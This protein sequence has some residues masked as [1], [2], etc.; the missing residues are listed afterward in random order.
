MKKLFYSE[1]LRK[2]FENE[3]DCVKAEKDYTEKLDAE[4]RRKEELAAQRKE[5]A[6]EIEDAYKKVIEDLKH[7]RELRNEFI[8]DYG[9]FHMSYSSKDLTLADL[10]DNWFKIF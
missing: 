8:D 7:Y 3:E 5:R 10:F 1:V 6:K 2:Y 9:H 4:K